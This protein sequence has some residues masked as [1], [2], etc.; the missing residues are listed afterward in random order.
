MKAG[1]PGISPVAVSSDGSP[2]AWAT[3][4]TRPKSST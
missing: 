1:V 2:S 4:F 3:D